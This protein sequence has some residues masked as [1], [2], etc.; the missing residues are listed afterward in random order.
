M[1]T[2]YILKAF[3]RPKRNDSDLINNN[4][5]ASSN[6][7][8]EEL[9]SDL[10]G[11]NDDD[12]DVSNANPIAQFLQRGINGG[13]NKKTLNKGYPNN[14]FL[15]VTSLNAIYN[16]YKFS[17]EKATTG[18]YAAVNNLKA[19]QFRKAF[20]RSNDILR[21]SDDC[22][23]SLLSIEESF[24]KDVVPLAKELEGCGANLRKLEV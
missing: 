18:K 10:Y 24:L 6:N 4:G 8:L 17:M 19:L 3:R 13:V 5:F 11:D 14:E 2:F 9:L 7:E 20:R 21:L 1:D 22:I 12:N 16:S 23:S 15:R